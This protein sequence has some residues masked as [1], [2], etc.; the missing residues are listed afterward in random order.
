MG[1]VESGLLRGSGCVSTLLFK[2]SESLNFVE[3]LVDIRG[4]TRNAA[5]VQQISGS[6]LL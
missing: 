1:F 4:E 6:L 2:V 3:L 5:A